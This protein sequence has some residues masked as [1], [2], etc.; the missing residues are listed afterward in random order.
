[1]VDTNNESDIEQAAR[2]KKEQDEKNLKTDPAVEGQK[3]QEELDKKEK[4]E[5][6]AAEKKAKKMK[7]LSLFGS[8][9]ETLSSGEREVYTEDK[10]KAVPAFRKYLE[11]MPDSE[12][13]EHLK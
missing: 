6:D 10:V 7:K 9:L 3:N 4:E 11:N 12:V 13:A 8:F 1:M 5:K 2:L